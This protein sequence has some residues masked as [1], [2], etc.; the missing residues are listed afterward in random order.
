MGWLYNCSVIDSIVDVPGDEGGLVRIYFARSGFDFTGEPTY[1]VA[2]YKIY[3]RGN[4]LGLGAKQLSGGLPPGAW[5]V[6]DSVTAT[7]Q[8]QYVR[9][10]PSLADFVSTPIYS[11]YCVRAETAS[12]PVYFYSPPDSG[13]SVDNLPP[14]PPIGLAGDYGYPPPELS[15][16]WE[17]NG[18]ADLSHYA[19][20]KGDHEGFAPGESNR[21]GMP[22]DTFLVDD[23][24]DPNVDNYYKV[25]A[26][27]VHGNESSY[28]LLR[29]DEVTDV[30]GPPAVPSVTLLEQNVPN[31]F[32]PVTVIRFSIAEPGRVTLAVYDV[33]GRPVRKLVEGKKESGFYSEIWDGRTDDGTALPSG[34]YICRLEAGD[35]TATRKLVLLR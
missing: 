19:V 33:A 26:W 20:Y 9:V 4:G 13:Y 27:D 22:V 14:A 10:V 5:E 1:P 25:S 24:F 11:V 23:G 12:P 29:P 35:F 17:P 16:T 32:N 21:L 15:I 2:S 3:R 30:S 6:V 28:S 31:P 34:V 18:E 8:E 7:R